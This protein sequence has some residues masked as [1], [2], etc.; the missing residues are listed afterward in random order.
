MTLI[1]FSL[2]VILLSSFYT[3][4]SFG[5]TGSGFVQTRIFN[6]AVSLR[7]G[8]NAVSGEPS[9]YKSQSFATHL[10]SHGSSTVDGEGQTVAEPLHADMSAIKEGIKAL[11]L[12]GSEVRVGILMARW[13]ADV[14]SG[15]YQVNGSTL[16]HRVVCN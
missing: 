1:S 5:I 3:C 7:G 8:A 11:S 9:A 4:S 13:N 16:H 14:I 12:D 10:S 15:L 6:R 2:V